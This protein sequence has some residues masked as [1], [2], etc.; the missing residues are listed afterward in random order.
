[1]VVA[2]VVLEATG[3][4]QR[5]A[6]ARLAVAGFKVAVVNPRQ[7]R[8]FARATGRLAKTDRLDARAVALFGAAVRPAPKPL[9]QAAE[10]R[11]AELVARRGQLSDMLV[12]EQ[13][14]LG[15]LE[16]AQLG[17]SVARHAEWLKKALKTLDLELDDAVRSSPLWLAK[18]E[19]LSSVPGVGKVVAR[20]LLAELPELGRLT[21]R[22]V[23]ALVGVAPFSRDSGTMRGKRPS[24]AVG[25]G[26]VARS[27]WRRWSPPGAIRLSE[28]STGTCAAT[29]RS[30]RLRSPRACAS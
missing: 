25:R 6:A 1:M 5:L 22:E 9:A 3:K 14:R 28:V 21:R 24:G 26:C 8:D 4:L 27:T 15:G 29:E 17:R 23:A 11:L 12:A 20:V 16:D 2:L 19:L 18:Q 13:N 7:V 30:P 10:R